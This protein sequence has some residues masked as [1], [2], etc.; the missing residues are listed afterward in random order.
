MKKLWNHTKETHKFGWLGAVSDHN[1]SQR[2]SYKWPR[3]LDEANFKSI[4]KGQRGD[5]H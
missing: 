4:P 3:R 2:R 5:V 1:L